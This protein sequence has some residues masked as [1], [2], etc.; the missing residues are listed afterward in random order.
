MPSQ[1][2]E[3]ALIDAL[4]AS[5]PE[6]ADVTAEL[7]SAGAIDRDELAERIGKAVG[8]LIRA[9]D[10]REDAGQS[11]PWLN[12]RCVC[13][14]TRRMHSPHIDPAEPCTAGEETGEPCP[15]ERFDTPA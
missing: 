15:C 11:R 7:K 3:N 1:A 9:R 13:G 4:T 8:R 10:G 12:A 2:R 14:H 6:L 5:L